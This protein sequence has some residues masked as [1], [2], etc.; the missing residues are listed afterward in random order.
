MR[1]VASLE[2]HPETG[3]WPEI[4]VVA[5]GL[6]VIAGL[7]L[8][9]STILIPGE[10]PLWNDVAVGALTVVLACVRVGGAWDLALLSYANAML[11]L[12]LAV[13][14]L[15]LDATSAGAANDTITG[16]AIFCLGLLSATA[17]RRGR[18]TAF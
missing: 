14:G 6:N 9:V 10:Q 2:S 1:A 8:L 13:S 12:A 16:L 17:S 7:W 5:S 3:D 4:V 15:S 18:A 11:G